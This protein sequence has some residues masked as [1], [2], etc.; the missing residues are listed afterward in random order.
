MKAN[1]EKNPAEMNFVTEEIDDEGE[2]WSGEE[3]TS[4][5]E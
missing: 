1:T 5:S 2:G 4:Q 3:A